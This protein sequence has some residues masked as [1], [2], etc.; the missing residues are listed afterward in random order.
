MEI[1]EGEDIA[2]DDHGQHDRDAEHR[3]PVSP[4]PAQ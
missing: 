1:E 4:E 3:A 2:K